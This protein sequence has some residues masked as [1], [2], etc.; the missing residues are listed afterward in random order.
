MRYLLIPT[1]VLKFVRDRDIRRAGGQIRIRTG[2]PV[3]ALGLRLRALRTGWEGIKVTQRHVAEALEA[4]GAL[5]SA[6]ENGKAVPPPDR[7][8]AYARFFATPRSMTKGA[9]RLLPTLSA[10]EEQAR[11]ALLDELT[12]LAADPKADPPAGPDRAPSLDGSF[13]HLLLQP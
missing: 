4:S 5:V 10:D 2:G 6:W 11:V 12:A 13:W 1:E 7:L 3:D 8:Q 9:G